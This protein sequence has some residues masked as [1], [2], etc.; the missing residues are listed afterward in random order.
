M[1]RVQDR[2]FHWEDKKPINISL[3]LSKV[4]SVIVLASNVIT[5]V[6][7]ASHVITVKVLVNAVLLSTILMAALVFSISSLPALLGF[8]TMVV[9]SGSMGPAIRTGDSVIIRPTPPESLAVGFKDGFIRVGDVITFKPF[10]AGGMV[11]HKVIAIKEM[12][13]DTFF[14]TQGDANNAPDADLVAGG[15]V[16]G[17]AAMTLPRFGY[18][19]HFIA[20]PLGSILLLILPVL[21]LMA[22]EIQELL[23]SI[24]I[25][26]L[27]RSR[28]RPQSDKLGQTAHE[29]ATHEA[30]ATAN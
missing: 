17:K 27:L 4:M 30:L 15:A 21:I 12:Q 16:Y 11:T 18:V 26:G 9:T 20:T 7:L 28:N 3:P 19:L 2:L 23:Q 29:A 10:G 24:R 1:A 6:V 13:G 22:R 25:K 14:Q 5:A 8:K